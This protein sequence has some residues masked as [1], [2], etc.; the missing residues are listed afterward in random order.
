LRALPKL[1]RYRVLDAINCR[2]DLVIARV[3]IV[4]K[5]PVGAIGMHKTSEKGKEL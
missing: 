4:V 5:D 2:S 3:W 1:N